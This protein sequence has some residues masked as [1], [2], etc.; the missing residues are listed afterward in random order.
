MDFTLIQSGFQYYK[1]VT[2][3]VKV[4]VLQMKGKQFSD[5]VITTV[6]T[7]S[8]VYICNDDPKQRN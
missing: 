5:F 6:P 8:A 1:K 4:T 7:G 3:F 2:V